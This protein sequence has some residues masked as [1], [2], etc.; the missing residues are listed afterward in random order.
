MA[1]RVVHII[2]TLSVG[3]AETALY[4]LLANSDRNAFQSVVITLAEADAVAKQISDLGIE[5]ISLGMRRG[6]P[7]PMALVR[8]LRH[9]RQ[10][11]PHVVQSWMYHAD[12]LTTV[13]FKLARAPKLKLVWNIRCSAMTANPRRPLKI[14]RLLARLSRIPAAVVAN[15]RSGRDYHIVCGYAPRRWELIP[16][17]FD[18]DE[19]CDDPNGITSVR[20]ELGLGPGAPL[21]GL[22]ARFHEVKDHRTFLNAARLLVE[23]RPDAKFLLAGRGVTPENTALAKWIDEL[24]L[25]DRVCLLGE[26]DDIHRLTRALDVASLTS[27]FGEGFSNVVGEAMACGVPSAVTDI[28]DARWI[29]GD[30]GRVVA[31]RD[32]AALAAAW[33]ELLSL[34]PEERRDLGER[35]R[36]RIAEHFSLRTMTAAYESLYSEIA[37]NEE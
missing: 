1:I 15:S 8:L 29:V 30:T 28:G 3:G 22:M 37:A 7:N 33:E 23:R 11:R 6:V 19:F 14:V 16:N 4:R 21:I 36:R 2:T 18:L 5:V 34:S 27:S 25:A 31:P 13:A 20:A 26:R 24:N 12:L 32:P 35:A 17:G 10:L 9:L